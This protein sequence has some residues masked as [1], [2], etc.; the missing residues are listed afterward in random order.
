MRNKIGVFL[1]AIELKISRN[2]ES[3][4]WLVSISL[5]PQTERGIT[6]YKQ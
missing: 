2:E 5:K 3:L 4:W 6:N 1:A